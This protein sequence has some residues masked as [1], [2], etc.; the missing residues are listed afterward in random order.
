MSSFE[1]I[2]EENLKLINLESPELELKRVA[3]LESTGR[4]SLYEYHLQ[5]LVEN[6]AL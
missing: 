3:S 4:Y 6:F 1:E 5:I 2:K